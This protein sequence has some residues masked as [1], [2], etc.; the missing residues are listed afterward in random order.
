MRF[1]PCFYPIY[2]CAVFVSLFL[3]FSLR[4]SILIAF[5]PDKGLD[6]LS[7]FYFW[8]KEQLALLGT[9]GCWRQRFGTR[10]CFPRP[11]SRIL[12]QRELCFARAARVAVNRGRATADNLST[13]AGKWRLVLGCPRSSRSSVVVGSSC[14]RS[15]AHLWDNLWHCAVPRVSRGSPTDSTTTPTREVQHER[16]YSS[17][18]HSAVASDPLTLRGLDYG[19]FRL[20]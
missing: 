18:H 9:R 13:E 12:E 4:V 10:Q 1:S 8:S 20:P 11:L 5:G 3:V 7:S 16:T 17:Q 14:V 19:D 6:R 15:W 2:L